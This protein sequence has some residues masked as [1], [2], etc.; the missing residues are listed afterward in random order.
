MSLISKIIINADNELRYPSV[1]ELNSLK[2]YFK[3]TDQRISISSILRDKEQQIVQAAS[4]SIFKIHP[5]Y[6]APGGNAEGARKRS[7]CLR[8]YSWYLRLIT[9]GVLSGDKDSIEKIGIIGVREMY[10]SLGVPILG[11]IDSIECLKDGA[12]SFLD[13][14]QSLLVCPYFDFIIQG[15]S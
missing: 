11:M 6:I 14:E 1:G 13:D 8:D 4:K 15:M 9:Y 3:T 7:L 12:F 2:D 5:E 10:S